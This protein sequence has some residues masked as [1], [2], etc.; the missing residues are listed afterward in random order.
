VVSS[1]G[2]D[3]ATNGSPSNNATTYNRHCDVASLRYYVTGIEGMGEGDCPI[4]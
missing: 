4:S 2:T 1:G 3:L